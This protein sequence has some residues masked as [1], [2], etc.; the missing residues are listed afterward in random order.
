MKPGDFQSNIS[1]LN[2]SKKNYIM[3]NNQDSPVK[4]D[5]NIPVKPDRNPDSTQTKPG[6]N[7]SWKNNPDRVEEPNKIDPTRI[8]EPLLPQ[9]SL[10]ESTIYL[11]K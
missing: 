1:Q 3:E 4:P 8:D 7:G 11:K 5:K 9:P 2:V 6:G 10:P